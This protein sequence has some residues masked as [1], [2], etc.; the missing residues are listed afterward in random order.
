MSQ[1]HGA[2]DGSLSGIQAAIREAR[3]ITDREINHFMTAQETLARPLT[4][5]N[6]EER[7][8]KKAKGEQM[9]KSQ[10]IPATSDKHSAPGIAADVGPSTLEVSIAGWFGQ[11]LNRRDLASAISLNVPQPHILVIFNLANFTVPIVVRIPEKR[12]P[13]TLPASSASPPSTSSAPHAS[14]PASRAP[15]PRRPLC[16]RRQRTALVH[17][18]QYGDDEVVQVKGWRGVRDAEHGGEAGIVRPTAVELGVCPL[19]LLV[20][21]ILLNIFFT[22]RGVAK[23]HD[24]GDITAQEQELVNAALPQL[25]KNIEK[26]FAFVQ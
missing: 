22:A 24:L 13:T 8:S 4:N 19:Q 7:S 20:L 10:G 3:P 2:D 25:K 14:S 23:I 11:R 18:I 26:G 12:A 6:T 5:S 16:H 15:I 17:K 1:G 21:P 9:I